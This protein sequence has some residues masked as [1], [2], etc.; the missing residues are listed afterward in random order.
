MCTSLL[1]VPIEEKFPRILNRGLSIKQIQNLEYT[2]LGDHISKGIWSKIRELQSPD[3][4]S[5]KWTCD[6]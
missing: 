3:T 4:S 2:K 5:F 1:T 6:L